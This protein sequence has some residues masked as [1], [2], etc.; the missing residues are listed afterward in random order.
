MRAKWIRLGDVLEQRASEQIDPDG[1]YRIAGVLG[2]A[3]GVL[4]RG[5][6]QG[7]ETKYRVL[8]RLNAGDV[9]YSK[10]K[11]FEGAVAVA[12]DTADG[13]FVSQEF[14]VFSVDSEI[15]GAYLRHVIAAP[16]FMSALAEQSTGL[17]VRRER[18]HATQFLALKI[19]LP[20]RDRRDR[21]AAHLDSFARLQVFAWTTR[22]V[23]CWRS[24][25]DSVR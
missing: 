21:I 17:G 16:R 1:T 23:Q 14:P 12:T 4:L 19:P 8:T 9:I 25:R 18:V 11:A 2:F 15:S 22:R 13:Y 5:P 3:R 24:A 20:T 7:H 6:I 10:L